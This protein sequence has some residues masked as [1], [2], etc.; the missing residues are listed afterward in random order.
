MADAEGES[1]E[2]ISHSL[3]V[4]GDESSRRFKGLADNVREF[5]KKLQN[6]SISSTEGIR[7]IRDIRGQFE[8]FNPEYDVSKCKSCGNID[9]FLEE[10]DVAKN[11]NTSRNNHYVD[12]DNM[13]SKS[14]VS[15]KDMAILYGGQW[16]GLGVDQAIDYAVP[17]YGMPIK[18]GLAAALPIVSYF[19]KMPKHIAEVLVL[20]GG[21]L[22]TKLAEYVQQAIA[23][24]VAVRK[25]SVRAPAT[26]TAAPPQAVGIAQ[27]KYVIT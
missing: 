24:A 26:V 23:P 11:L 25:V 20:T 17:Q 18:L 7:A 9:G 4:E 2:A 1:E 19:V 12:D 10:F 14:G 21:Y 8:S 5:R 16:V 15:G 6:S 3:I 22:S 27:T 13:K